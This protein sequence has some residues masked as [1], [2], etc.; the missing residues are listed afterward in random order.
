MLDGIKYI[1]N[2]KIIFFDTIELIILIILY[3]S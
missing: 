1:N 2:V 3:Q